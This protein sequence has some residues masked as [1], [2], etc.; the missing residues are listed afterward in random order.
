MSFLCRISGHSYLLALRL[1]ARR[2][3]EIRRLR[4]ELTA[5]LNEREY[6]RRQITDKGVNW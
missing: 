4:R 6:L 3:R 5:L 1:I 2:E